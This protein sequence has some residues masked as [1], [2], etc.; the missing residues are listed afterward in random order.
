MENLPVGYA[1]VISM[2]GAQPPNAS[3]P[4]GRCRHKKE[5]STGTPDLGKSEPI[6]RSIWQKNFQKCAALTI[7]RT[8]AASAFASLDQPPDAVRLPYSRPWRATL[9]LDTLIHSK[10]CFFRQRGPVEPDPGQVNLAQA[11]P[12]RP[13]KAPHGQK[14]GQEQWQ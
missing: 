10:H 5:P 7:E 4:N 6:D 3:Q 9:S 13:R 1:N 11:R 8:L 12:G 2:Y 14:H